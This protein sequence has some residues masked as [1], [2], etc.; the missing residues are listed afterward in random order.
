MSIRNCVVDGITMMGLMRGRGHTTDGK[1]SSCWSEG[2][3]FITEEHE[4]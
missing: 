2:Q 1:P 3:F 4:N